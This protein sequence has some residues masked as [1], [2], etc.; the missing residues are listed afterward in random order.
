M[1]FIRWLNRRNFYFSNLSFQ[2]LWHYGSYE[3]NKK[4]QLNISEIMR[5]RPKKKTGT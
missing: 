1:N 4:F 5:A 3:K 2:I